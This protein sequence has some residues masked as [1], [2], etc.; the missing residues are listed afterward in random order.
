MGMFSVFPSYTVKSYVSETLANRSLSFE[1]FEKALKSEASRQNLVKRGGKID[2]GDGV[3][4][5][6]LGPTEG[7]LKRTSPGGTISE[8][9][10]FASLVILVTYGT[11]SVILT[12]DSQVSGLVDANPP[13]IDV[14]HVPHHGSRFGL[15]AQ[16]VD[17]MDPEV[18]VISVGKNNYGHPTKEVLKILGDKDIKIFRTDQNGEVEIVSDGRGYLMYD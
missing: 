12:G 17:Q 1:E 4:I 7:F 13:D 6:V 5:S 11:F 10:E 16:I 8:T 9:G 15:D 3:K 2:L 18:A 14:L